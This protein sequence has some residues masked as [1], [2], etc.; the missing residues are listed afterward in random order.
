[1]KFP[2]TLKQELYCIF[3]ASLRAIEVRTGIIFSPE[4][5]IE[6]RIGSGQVIALPQHD[7]AAY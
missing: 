4:G 1:M 6:A 5:V 3:Y 7:I 2:I